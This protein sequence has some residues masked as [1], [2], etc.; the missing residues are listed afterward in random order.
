ME[1]HRKSNWEYF[2][3]LM[4]AVPGLH[5]VFSD[6]YLSGPD[7]EEEGTRC[8]RA[9]AMYKQVQDTNGEYFTDRE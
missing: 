1:Q 2:C 5:A 8:D 4:A 6:T 3:R 7:G 9:V